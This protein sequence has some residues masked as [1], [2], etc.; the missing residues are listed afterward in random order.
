VRVAANWIPVS[1]RGRVLGIIGTSYQFMASITYLIAG[2]CVEAFGW[3]GAFFLP[4]A[5]LIAAAVHMLVFLRETPDEETIDG[6]PPAPRVHLPMR[7]VF[8]LTITNSS[9]WV[10]AVTLFLMDACRYFYQDWGLA[11]LTEVQGSSVWKSAAQYSI[12]PAGGIVGAL[13]GGWATDRF[14]NGRRAPVIFAN[15]VLL[16]T[17][18]VFYDG[19]TRTSATGTV[20]LL[21]WIGFAIFGSQVLLVGT[22][23]TDLARSGTA[24]AAAGFVN[25]MGYMGAF[26]GDT[27]TGFLKKHYNWETAISFWSWVAFAAAWMILPLWRVGPRPP[28]ER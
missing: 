28:G 7:H 11:H 3:R 27:I 14:F 21:F 2:A 10:L 1:R 18:T 16:G 24:A 9:L 19:V 12:L 5:L 15:L 25:F 4:A 23:P 26:T 6:V 13:F 17:L 8:K 22:A 20:M